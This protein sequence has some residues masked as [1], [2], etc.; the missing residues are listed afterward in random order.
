MADKEQCDK[1]A[2]EMAQRY[3]DFTRWAIENWPHKDA[4]LL[5]S[6]L[7][8]SR[9]EIAFILG[10]KLTQS[11]AARAAASSADDAGQYINQNPAPWP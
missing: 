7:S 5:Q 8:S 3:E 9:R 1:F 6:D 4:P 2:A 11:E 10:S